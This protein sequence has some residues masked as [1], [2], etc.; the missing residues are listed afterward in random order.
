MARHGLQQAIVEIQQALDNVHQAWS[1]TVAA[2]QAGGATTLP[3]NQSVNLAEFCRRLDAVVHPLWQFYVITCRYQEGNHAFQ[4]TVNA[5]Q[6]LVDELGERAE[7]WQQLLTKLLGLQATFLCIQGQPA[8]ALTIAIAAQQRSREWQSRDGEIFALNALAHIHYSQG[9]LAQAKASAEAILRIVQQPAEVGGAVWPSEIAYSAQSMMHIYLGAIA[10]IQDDYAQAVYH[11]TQTLDLCQALGKVMGTM[12]ARMNLA[13]L[14]RSKQAYAAARQEYEAVI[15]IACQ[16]GNLRG[17]GLAR[18][19]LADSLRGLGEYALALP[20]FTQALTLFREIG[21]PLLLG[22]A[23]SSL[24]IYYTHLGDYPTAQHFCRQALDQCEALTMPDAKPAAWLAA[25][26]FYHLTGDDPQ[27][28]A[29]ATRSRESAQS[30]QSRQGEASALLHM[31]F[32]YEGL[33]LWAAAADAYCQAHQLY[34]RLDIAP[35]RLEAEAGLTRLA[36]AQGHLVDAS[37]WAEQILTSLPQQANIGLYEPFGIY[38]TLYHVLTA[39]ADPRAATVLQQG[40]DLLQQVATTL[41][42]AVRQ[43]FLTTVPVNRRLVAAYLA[44]QTRT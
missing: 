44:W 35:A 36:L 16:L 43:R 14:A 41:D 38:S 2:I 28:L 39:N 12:D 30:Q 32:A 20:Q 24:A 10:R 40:Y 4:Q 7:G 33:Q 37:G 25:A 26:I 5:V 15:Q 1:W 18:Y 8:Q 9:E 34:Q 21:D 13:N 17:E 22:Y 6:S 19:E 27:A 11:F 42:E 3:V 29:Y 23:S 31:A